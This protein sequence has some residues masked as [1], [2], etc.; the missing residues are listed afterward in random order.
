M[1]T[2]KRYQ[3][4]F[5]LLFLGSY[6]ALSCRREDVYYQGP[7]SNDKTAP[8]LSARSLAT[9]CNNPN[10]EQ[11]F[12]S[13]EY[14]YELVDNYHRAVREGRLCETLNEKNWLFTET[15]PAEAIQKLLEQPGCC[16]FRI[17]NGLDKE[18]RVHFVMVGVSARGGDV[19][20]CSDPNANRD[21]CKEGDLPVIVEMGAPCPEACSGNY[22]GP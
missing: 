1:S 7:Y 16:K 3:H 22:V 17:Y 4:F 8:S 21:S 15:F 19:L 11:H 14:A 6:L 5:L 13:I 12:I 18:N 20:Y 2:M 10:I 9:G